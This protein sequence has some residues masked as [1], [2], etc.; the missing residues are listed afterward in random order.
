MTKQFVHLHVHTE[1]SLLDGA[2][3]LDDMFAE[4][5]RQGAPAIAMTDHGNLHGSHDFYTKAMRA[6]VKPIIGIEAYTA[7][8]ARQDQERQ[9][10]GTP[11][12]KRYDV[13]ARGAY[14]HMTLW[15][16]N[17]VGLHNLMR[18]TSRSY[19]EGMLGKYPRIDDELLAELAPGLMG[20]TGCPG[21]AVMTRLNLGQYDEAVAIAAKRQDILGKGNY[22]LELMDHGIE[23]ESRVRHDLIRLGRQLGIKPVV[24]NDSHYTREEESRAHD[25]LLCVQTGSDL[26]N[27]NRFRFEGSGY[28]LKSAAEM[29]AIAPGDDV[30]Q[31]GMRTTLEIAERVDPTGMYE[32]HNLMPRF[33]V[34]KGW[35]EA[36]WFNA[37]AHKGMRKRFPNGFSDKHAYQLMYEIDMIVEMG[38]PSYFLVVA[39]Y[40]NWAKGQGI[41]VGPGRGSAAGSLVSYALGI[42]DLDPLEHGLIFERFLNP[43]RIQMPDMDIDFDDRRRHEVIQ[44][45]TKKYGADKVAQIGTFGRIKAKAAIKDSNRVLGK[46]FAIGDRITKAFPPD[47]QGNSA[48]LRVITDPK[49]PRY[50]EAGEVRSLYESDPDVREVVDTALGIEGLV[51]QMGVHAAGVIMSSEPITDYVPVWVRPA[52]GSVITQFDFPT[53]E[54]LGLVK[55]DFLGLRNLTIMNDAVKNIAENR[56]EAVDLDTIPLDDKATFELMARGDTLSVFQLDGGAMRNLLRLMQPTEFEHVSAVVALYRPG[57]MGANSHTNYALRKIG[58]QEITPI[59]PEVAE[60]L[61]EILDVSYGLIIYQEQVMRAAQI[62]AGYSLAQ[63]DL[64]RKAMGKKKAEILEKE[65]VNFEAGCRANG[66]SDEAIRAVWDVLVPFSGYAFNKAHSA[67][68]GLIAYRTAWL[69]AHYPAEYMA[70]VLTSVGDDRAKMALYLAECRRMG[71]RVKAPDVNVSNDSFTPNGD[72]EIRFGLAAVK[73]VGEGVVQEIAEIREAW[74]DFSSLPNFLL[75]LTQGTISK[76]AIESLI[77]AGAFDTT[78]ATRRGMA[79]TYE[80]VAD[81]AKHG[82]QPGLVIAADCEQIQLPSRSV[83]WDKGHMLAAEREMLGLYVSDHPLA[84]LEAMLDSRSDAAVSYLL[85]E[86][87]IEGETVTIGG[88]VSAVELKTSKRGGRWAIAT[89]EDRTGEIEVL[90][91]SAAYESVAEHLERDAILFVTGRLER[92][93]GEPQLIGQSVSLPRAE[94]YGSA[95]PVVVSLPVQLLTEDV[96]G[97]LAAILEGYPGQ[98]EVQLH[99]STPFGIEQV[100][101]VG[102]FKVNDCI[103]LHAELDQ[104]THLTI[105]RE[106]V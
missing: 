95:E 12:Q 87:A 6:G 5:Q 36:D 51:R 1:Y 9:L 16:E 26:A 86:S 38:F 45:V 27:P 34:P 75:A 63:A 57:P 85:D 106:D 30:W 100:L 25:T 58:Q 65:F 70:A 41:G 19:Q 92:R 102:R 24:T 74:G 49:A 93:D 37:E 23:I 48:P 22:F 96:A 3:K 64:L 54:S 10:W 43:E 90:F 98:T 21:G 68:Y 60:P 4:M 66:Y 42:T 97:A 44:Y 84:G 69:K 32:T 89:V 2:A 81:Q 29:A 104:F 76:R 17:K 8:G 50:S 72:K 78:G 55:M 94:D 91:F 73:N 83:S 99:L 80:A 77:K 13:S 35:T 62:L 71:L 18:L 59:H 56:G 61:A 82:Q 79:E 47:V 15:A 14:T 7:P 31:W 40:I 103:A 88:L 101:R 52:D 20:T 53:C 28:Y 33:D 39:D 105:N 46:P 11:D 67:A